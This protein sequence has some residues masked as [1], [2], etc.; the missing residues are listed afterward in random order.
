MLEAE[1][2]KDNEDGIAEIEIEIEY[3][4]GRYHMNISTPTLKLASKCLDIIKT[5]QK[6]IN[7]LRRDNE[8][9][10]KNITA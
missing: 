7:A 4:K 9:L 8:Q 3:L 6:T 10:A 2:I 1:P 5:Y